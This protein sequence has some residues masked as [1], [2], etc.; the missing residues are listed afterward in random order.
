MYAPPTPPAGGEARLPPGCVYPASPASGGPFSGLLHGGAPGSAAPA[1]D[2]RGQGGN[3]ATRISAWR[4]LVD[5]ELVD[6]QECPCR[7]EKL[8]P[9]LQAAATRPGI[10]E[11]LGEDVDVDTQHATHPALP[12]WPH[13]ELLY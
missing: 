1:M 4:M 9:A 3:P 7:I 5:P 13:P 2:C 6:H 11:Y 12:R 10:I 8:R